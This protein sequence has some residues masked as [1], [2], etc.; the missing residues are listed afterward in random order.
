MFWRRCHTQGATRWFAGWCG[1]RQEVASLCD[2]GDGLIAAEQAAIAPPFGSC[3]AC[4][5]ESCVESYARIRGEVMA[6]RLVQGACAGLSL[7]LGRDSA[8]ARR[9]DRSS[10]LAAE[11]SRSRSANPD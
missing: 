11:I 7:A 3:G 6:K 1:N 8:R 4:G 9:K 2:P 10:S 5:A